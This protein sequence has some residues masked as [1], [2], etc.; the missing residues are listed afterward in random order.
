VHPAVRHPR[1]S[2]EY[3]RI[4]GTDDREPTMLLNGYGDEVAHLY[5]GLEAKVG[6]RLWR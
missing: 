1:W 6:D 5:D 4:L 2:Q 3:E